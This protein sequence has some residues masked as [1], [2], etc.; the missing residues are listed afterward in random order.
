MNQISPHDPYAAPSSSPV[1]HKLASC[2]G[3]T[4]ILVGA[5][6]G[7]GIVY[8]TLFVTVWVYLW[9]LSAAG[10]PDA[11]LYTRA[12]ESTWYLLFAHL[13][14]LLSL[15]PGGYWS[16]RL[17]TERHLFHAMLAG[18]II[19]GFSLLQCTFPY[20]LP[21]PLWSMIVSVVVPIPAFL[22]GAMWERRAASQD[23]EG[24][25]Q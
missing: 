19:S 17:S 5:A 23:F 15:L 20:E 22:L 25:R 6:V 4:A 9:G 12:Y 18:L 8:A 24:S 2:N 10:V 7:N 16:A 3:I 1:E 21:I 11:D 13:V 14:G